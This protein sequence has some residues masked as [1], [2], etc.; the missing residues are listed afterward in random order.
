ML[1]TVYKWRIWEVISSILK[2]KPGSIWLEE[3]RGFFV[4]GEDLVKRF[5]CVSEEKDPKEGEA[6]ERK[7]GRFLMVPRIILLCVWQ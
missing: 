3:A 1:N 7:G 5:D 2:L 4:I 6:W